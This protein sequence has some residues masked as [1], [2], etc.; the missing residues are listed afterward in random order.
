MGERVAMD[1]RVDEQTADVAAA[2]VRR[3][4]G[5]PAATDEG[6]RLHAEVAATNRERPAFNDDSQITV[7]DGCVGCGV[8]ARVC[9]AGNFYVEGGNAHTLLP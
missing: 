7:G 5:I 9:P 2:V 6:R 4:L 3:E 1:K 8:C